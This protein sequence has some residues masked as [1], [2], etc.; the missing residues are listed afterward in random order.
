M[1]NINDDDDTSRQSTISSSLLIR[2]EKIELNYNLTRILFNKYE[3]IYE[4]IFTCRNQLFDYGWLL[5]INLK[6][7]YPNIRDDLVNLYHLLICCLNNIWKRLLLTSDF[8]QIKLTELDTNNPNSLLEHICKNFDANLIQVKTINEYYFKMDQFIGANLE[9]L[10]KLLSKSYE[11]S[12]NNSLINNAI[13]DRF[14]LENLDRNYIIFENDQE[15]FKL[16]LPECLSVLL[17]ES[18]HDS[19]LSTDVVFNK[20]F[21]ESIIENVNL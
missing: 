8:K 14:F 12:I 10:V 6:H 3:I 2:L 18:E 7:K 4:Q 9:N 1:L 13:D 21:K 5:F 11:N 17:D 19:S 16:M 15:F 20:L